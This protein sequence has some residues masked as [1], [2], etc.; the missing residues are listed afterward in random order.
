[1]FYTY[2]LG[3][4][5]SDRQDDIGD[6]FV[7]SGLANAIVHAKGPL[8]GTEEVAQRWTMRSSSISDP[9]IPRFKLKLRRG[10][11]TSENGIMTVGKPSHS[12]GIL[13]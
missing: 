9:A 10:G 1:M 4:K 8:P 13:Y 11:A 2:E 6:R 3:A 7:L 12:R 5:V